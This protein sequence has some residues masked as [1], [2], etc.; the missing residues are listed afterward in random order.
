MLTTETFILQW[1]LGMVVLPRS[2]SFLKIKACISHLLISDEIFMALYKNHL[3]VFKCEH[4]KKLDGFCTNG[5]L[6]QGWLSWPFSRLCWRNSDVNVIRGHLNLVEQM[7][8]FRLD[9]SLLYL[10]V[11]S[12]TFIRLNVPNRSTQNLKMQRWPI[13]D[14]ILETSMK[15]LRYKRLIS[16]K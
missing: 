4:M 12:S 2:F 5:Y 10:E 9:P 16:W 1:F 13:I 6:S 11:C 3:R 14:K 8:T 7:H 15:K